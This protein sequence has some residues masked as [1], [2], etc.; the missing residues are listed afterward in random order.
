MK[1]SVGT[2]RVE[3]PPR[4][5]WPAHGKRVLR[6]RRRRRLRSVDSDRVGRVIQPRKAYSCGG[7]RCRKNGRQHRCADEGCTAPRAWRSDPPGSQERG[8]HERVHQ[9]PGRSASLLSEVRWAT[10]QQPRSARVVLVRAGAKTEHI[11]SE[12]CP[13]ATKGAARGD[14]R[15]GQARRGCRS[16]SSS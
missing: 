2:Q 16:R 15:G 7:R 11:E 3:I 14:A 5:N 1:L 9:E 6:G 4:E 12:R 10:G 13:K 8:T